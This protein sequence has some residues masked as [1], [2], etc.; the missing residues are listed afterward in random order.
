MA[1]YRV[2]GPDG[3]IY[4]VRKKEVQ[5]TPEYLNP[6][7]RVPEMGGELPDQRQDGMPGNSGPMAEQAQ[8]AFLKAIPGIGSL[9]PDDELGKLDNM[10]QRRRDAIPVLSVDHLTPWFKHSTAE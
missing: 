10:E 1:V 7:G 2:K 5:D 9:M 3:K 4:K 8:R 6:T